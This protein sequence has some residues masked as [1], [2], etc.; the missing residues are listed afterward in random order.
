MNG[1]EIVAL[2]LVAVTAAAFAWRWWRR[3]RTGS[4]PACGHCCGAGSSNARPLN[5]H[6]R[7][8]KH[9]PVTLG[10]TSPNAGKTST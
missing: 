1:Q 4:A 3:R 2:S 10:L 9:G 8:T 7:A 6:L 5:V